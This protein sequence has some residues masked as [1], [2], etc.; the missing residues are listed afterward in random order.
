MSKK[1]EN[2]ETGELEVAAHSQRLATENETLN[3]EVRD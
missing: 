3:K 1:I 2:L